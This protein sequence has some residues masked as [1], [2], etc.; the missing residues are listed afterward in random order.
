MRWQK[1]NHCP[2]QGF[3]HFTSMNLPS[4][5]LQAHQETRCSHASSFCPLEDITS[6]FNLSFEGHRAHIVFVLWVVPCCVLDPQ[7]SPCPGHVQ[8]QV[9]LFGFIQQMSMHGRK[10]FLQ[11]RFDLRPKKRLRNNIADLLL[12]GSISGQWAQSLFQDAH[13]AAAAGVGEL[14]SPTSCPG[15]SLRN[16][17]RRLVK[18]S[19]WPPHGSASAIGEPE[20]SCCL[21]A[22]TVHDDATWNIARS[23][24]QKQVCRKHAFLLSRVEWLDKASF[25]GKLPKVQFCKREM[26]PSRPLDRWSPGEMG[27]KWESD[28]SLTE[29]SRSSRS[30]LQE[31]EDTS[32]CFESRNSALLQA[33]TKCLEYISWSLALLIQ[34]AFPSSGPNGKAITGPPWRKKRIGQPLCS[35]AILAEIRGDWECWSHLV[36][37]CHSGWVCIWWGQ[38]PSCQPLQVW[39][40]SS[41]VESLALCLNTRC[42]DPLKGSDSL[43]WKNNSSI[44]WWVWQCLSSHRSSRLI[45]W[46]NQHFQ[47]DNAV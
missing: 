16:L 18:G 37:H 7:S 23:H 45:L 13:S 24:G 41:G 27:S 25:W 8:A 28:C 44:L 19:K 4:W 1:M 26:H 3:A 2:D 5:K 35:Y 43:P 31:V 32:D 21:W 22:A 14:A 46:R 33:S 40:L 20:D 17:Q 36:T 6:N 11:E 39:W 12:D 15:N 34:D 47:R 30:N 10:H 9:F 42:V 38:I 29:F